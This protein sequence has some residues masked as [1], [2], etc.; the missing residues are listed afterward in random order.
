MFLRA[1]AKTLKIFLKAT[2]LS[3]RIFRKAID[4]KKM[5][6]TIIA[7]VG[8]PLETTPHRPRLGDVVMTMRITIKGDRTGKL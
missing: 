2:A 4:T 6:M 5:T 3:P 7:V 8:A 1:I